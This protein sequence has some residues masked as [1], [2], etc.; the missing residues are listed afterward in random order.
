MNSTPPTSKARQPARSLPAI[1]DVSPSAKAVGTRA[2]NFGFIL[3]N[4]NL[5]SLQLLCEPHPNPATR[6][7]VKKDNPGQFEG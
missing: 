3:R 1:I 4:Q 6:I 7:V 2:N 5:A